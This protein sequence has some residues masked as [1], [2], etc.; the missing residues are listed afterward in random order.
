MTFFGQEHLS[1][2]DFDLWPQNV[3]DVLVLRQ[4]A[5]AWRDAENRYMQ[6]TIFR[7]HG[8][9][10]SELWRL[11]YWDPTHQLVVDAMHCLLEGL[12]QQHFRHTLKLTFDDASAK[13]APVK[14]FNH[15]FVVPSIA[16][17]V[18][19]EWP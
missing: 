12:A 10:W 14:A 2:L 17:G 11:P 1:N 3:R 13:A 15:V 8:V 6:E 7:E 18:Y 19:S 16:E 9:R 4:Q 5:E